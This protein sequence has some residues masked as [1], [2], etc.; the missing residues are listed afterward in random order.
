MR[1]DM[2]PL[3]QY[4]FLVRCLVKDRDNFTSLSDMSYDLLLLLLLVTVLD[5]QLYPSSSLNGST[6]L[7]LPIGRY[8]RSCSGMT[9]RRCEFE[10]LYI[11]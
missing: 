9:S 3:P 2:P 5:S 7:R 6:D 1:G 10:L 4:I 8:S 11:H